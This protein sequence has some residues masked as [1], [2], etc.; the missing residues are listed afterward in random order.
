MGKRWF[1]GLLAVCLLSSSICY[2]NQAQAEA[3]SVS[4]LK[5]QQ[6][7]AEQEVDELEKAKQ[8]L[9]ASLGDMNSELYQVSNSIQ[10]LQIQIDSAEDEIARLEQELSEAETAE[11]QQYDDMK[12]RIQYMYE[13][14][15]N[16]SWTSLLESRSLADFLNRIQYISD[17]TGYDRQML[18]DYQVTLENIANCKTQ[19]EQEQQML[20]ASKEELSQ[21]ENTLLASIADVQKNLGEKADELSDK[22]QEADELADKIAAMEAYEKQLEEQRAKEDAKRLEEIRKQEEESDDSI[23]ATVTPQ[24]GEEE[25][26]AAIIY[27]E[28]GGE[29]YEAQLAVGSV[30]LNRVNSPYFANTITGVIYEPKQFSPAGSGKLALVL[31]NGLTTESCRNAA[32][33]V[34]GGHITGNWLY[35]RVDNGTIDGT[36]IGKQVFY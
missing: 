17:I 18:E 5:G 31:E 22:Q 35:F 29:S 32:R 25:L 30:V 36:V 3:A 27:C 14:G 26:L 24:T 9:E 12:L 13:N 4:D 33:E 2:N 15:S 20:L 11:Q 8:E 1:P 34:L 16:F 28:A 7:A 23:G 19:L 10:E 6:E 21:K